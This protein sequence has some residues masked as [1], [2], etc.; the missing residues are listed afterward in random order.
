MDPERLPTP[1]LIE[2]C[3]GHFGEAITS[4]ASWVSIARTAMQALCARAEALS[5]E[6]T[7][8]YQENSQLLE[9]LSALTIERDAARKERDTLLGEVGRLKDL[10][11]RDRTGLAIALG[12]VRQTVKSYMWLANSGE[13]GCYDYTERT[14]ETLRGE[15]KNAFRD[16]FRLAEEALKESGRRA[17][18][19]FR[20]PEG[21]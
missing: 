12:A 18:A 16:I 2:H 21:R 14:V 8:R 20:P 5:A 7:A 1:E 10:L 11:N 15:I 9:W 3:R 4:P 6:A 13:W 17:D 19:A